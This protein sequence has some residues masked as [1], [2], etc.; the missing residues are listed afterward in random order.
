M[1]RGWE[2]HWLL[3]APLRAGRVTSLLGGEA[4]TSLAPAHDTRRL[5]GVA[6]T[7]P[8]PRD[9]WWEVARSDPHALVAQ[10][11][12]W[13]DALCSTERYR[14]A[15][16]LYELGD[17]A[18]MVLPLV[19]RARWPGALAPRASMPHA[20]GMGGLLSERA[21]TDAEIGALQADLAGIGALSLRIR[22]NPLQG[23]LW[24][25]WTGKGVTTAQGYA[26]VLDL[27]GGE[28]RVWEERLKKNARREVRRAEKAGVQVEG[29]CTGRLLPVYEELVHRSVERWARAQ[30]EPLA[31]ARWRARRRDPPGKLRRIAE[32]LGD[33][34][35]V[36]VAWHEGRPAAACIV[37]LGSNASDTRAAMDKDVAGP[38]SANSLLQWA[39]IQD[40][41]RR[42]CRHYHL[43]ESSRGSG[44]AAY[45]EKFGAQPVAYPLIVRERLPLER[46]AGSARRAV[47]RVLRFRDA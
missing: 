2:A 5:A 16:R 28:E 29:D 4:M 25:G 21:P 23:R 26:H 3:D 18:R 39:A 45:K 43:G 10:A 47:K 12:P 24:E 17:G 22:P 38:T 11:P 37:L 35:M 19:S 13:I 36:W 9:V 14:D 7:T 1:V 30:N 27:E 33:S 6:V 15:S 20:W 8:A 34:C 32:T 41:C 42:G 46:T 44:V 40:A 31:L